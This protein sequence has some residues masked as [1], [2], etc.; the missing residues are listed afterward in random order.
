VL[1]AVGVACV[2]IVSL[3]FGLRT[4]RRAPSTVT[5]TE[6]TATPEIAAL[7][8]V[9]ATEGAVAEAPDQDEGFAAKGPVVEPMADSGQA[10]K[11][12]LLGGRRAR[13]SGG[14]KGKVQP[15]PVALAQ[16]GQASAAKSGAPQAAAAQGYVALNHHQPAKAV[17]FFKK[18]LVTNPNNGTALFGLAEAYRT[19]NQFTPAL[20]AYRRYV[21]LL[22][23]GPDAGSA[24]HHIRTLESKKR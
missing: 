17:A 9:P 15:A 3:H 11:V 14:R 10:E 13:V 8:P 21:E 20:L 2:G 5:R 24:R 7:A 22:P 12:H 16:G 6:A 4:S 18:A 19:G 1:V 23:S